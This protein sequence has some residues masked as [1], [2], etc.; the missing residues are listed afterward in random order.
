MI[1]IFYFDEEG[2]K[3]DILTLVLKDGGE[4]AYF[5]FQMNLDT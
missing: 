2:I 5:S 1:I 3:A 4:S